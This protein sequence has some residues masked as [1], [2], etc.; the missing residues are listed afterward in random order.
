MSDWIA[1]SM[2][3]TPSSLDVVEVGSSEPWETISHFHAAYAPK[4]LLGIFPSYLQID[5]RFYRAVRSLGLSSLIVAQ[6][7]MQAGIA[8]IEPLLIGGIVTTSG[9]YAHCKEN[10]QALSPA[11]NPYVQVVLGVHERP[12][13]AGPSVF[14][15]VHDTPGLPLLY[16]CDALKGGDFHPT[17]R[18]SAGSVPNVTVSQNPCACGNGSLVRLT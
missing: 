3:A 10:L 7:Q 6:E 14:F 8:L 1:N 18:F 13:E 11:A 2:E 16:Q 12:F 5:A 17:K 15:E 9:A 4:L